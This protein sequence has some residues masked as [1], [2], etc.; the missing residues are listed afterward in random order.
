MVERCKLCD[1]PAT[2]VGC[3]HVIPQWMY[4]VLPQ[5]ESRFRIASSHDGEFEKRSPTGIYGRF[6]CQLCEDHFARWDSCASEVLRRI[7]TM[8]ANGWW[9][10]GEFGYGDLARFY[11]SVL[12][13]ASACGQPFFETVDLKDR[14]A[15]LATALLAKDDTCLAAFDIW[16][17]RSGRLLACGV[18]PPLEVS[19]EST[20]YWQLYMPLFQALIKVV[21][22]P[23]AS[24]VQP[25]KLKPNSHLL[26]CEK[27]FTEFGEVATTETVFR[28]NMEKKNARRR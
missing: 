28:A 6:V 3:S 13:R 16:P 26:L 5:D 23:G 22:G 1:L 8:S 20:P 10:Y 27:T 14:T 4:A 19:I 11:L 18:L 9:D 25:H 24:C 17:S 12:W 15:T 7:P 21:D 2:L